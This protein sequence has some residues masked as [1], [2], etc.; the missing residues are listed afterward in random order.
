MISSSS[1]S[2]RRRFY[3]LT[4]SVAK[5]RA[6]QESQVVS[7][8]GSEDFFFGM[9]LQSELMAS[10]ADEDG[11]PGA[12]VL[13]EAHKDH[14]LSAFFAGKDDLLRITLHVYLLRPFWAKRSWLCQTV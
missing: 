11:V 14:L 5:R 8:G 2:Y 6:V 13:F 10:L 7:V 12:P 3:V 9:I 4:M 1:Q